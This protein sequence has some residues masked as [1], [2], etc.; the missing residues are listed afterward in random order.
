MLLKQALYLSVNV[1]NTKLLTK[2]T[3]FTSPLILRGPTALVLLRL[4]ECFIMI[5]DVEKGSNRMN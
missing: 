4:N 5:N 3:I 1:F 2:D